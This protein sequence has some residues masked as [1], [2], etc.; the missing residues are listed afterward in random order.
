[1]HPPHEPEFTLILAKIL[2]KG[3]IPHKNLILDID[4]HYF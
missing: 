2:K 4:L 3:K 1:M